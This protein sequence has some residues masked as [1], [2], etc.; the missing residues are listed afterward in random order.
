MMGGAANGF[1]RRLGVG[2]VA[3]VLI[4][5]GGVMILN[6]IGD[7]APQVGQL[8]ETDWSDEVGETPEPALVDATKE[9]GLADRPTPPDGLSEIAGGMALA[10]LDRDGD[11]DLLVAQGSAHALMWNGTRFDEPIDLD[12]TEAMTVSTSDVD[13]DGWVDVLVGGNTVSDR[14]IWGGPWAEAGETPTDIRKLPGGRPTAALLAA[15]LTGDDRIDI[16]QLGRGGDVTDAL[17]VAQPDDPREF[18][19]EPFGTDAGLSMAGEIADV[20]GDGLLD[21]WVTRDVGWDVEPDVLYSRNG[22]DD[23]RWGDVSGDLGTDLAIDGMGVTLADLD[24]DAQLDAYLSDLGEN[25]ILQSTDN[26]FAAIGDLGAG[27]IRPVGADEAVISSSW[28]SGATDVNLDGQLD[29]VVVNGG[30]ANGKLQNKVPDTS[31]AQSDPPAVLVGIAGGRFVDMWPRLGIEWNGSSRGLTIGD[32][33]R[34]GDDDYLVL[35]TDGTIVALRNEISGESITVAANP[36]C[37]PT[38]AVLTVRHEAGVFHSLLAPHTYNG[39]H[40]PEAVVGIPAGDPFVTITWPGEQ[41]RP[42]AADP[43]TPDSRLLATC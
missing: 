43:S 31:I 15:D 20:D 23:D 22:P 37:D 29:L 8:F 10:D 36:A 24:G 41:P 38:G 33:D 32:I 21:V 4:G 6:R 1:L 39:A 19:A 16:V 34:D 2:A 11:L 42:V 12:V 40:S 7:D 35:N 17:W 3:A 13:R 9:W 14:I 28:A 30:F 5:V 26:G 18:L 27:R 25:D